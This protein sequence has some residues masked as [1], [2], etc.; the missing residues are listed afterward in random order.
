M[1][2]PRQAV[3]IGVLLA[4]AWGGC[5]Q[6]A[7]GP[8]P[9]TLHEAASVA[10]VVGGPVGIIVHT[11]PPSAASSDQFPPDSEFVLPDPTL[12]ERVR[13]AR[14][15]IAAPALRRELELQGYVLSAV[16]GGEGWARIARR[17]HC[18]SVTTTSWSP[19]PGLEY[20]GRVGLDIPEGAGGEIVLVVGDHG[21][22]RLAAESAAGDDLPLM[23]EPLQ[24][25]PGTDAPP[26]DFWLGRDDPR[27]APPEVVRVR[28]PASTEG[29]RLV[30]VRFGRRAPHVLARLTGYEGDARARV[31]AAPL[32]GEDIVTGDGRAADVLLDRPELYGAGW[33]G[34]GRVGA[35]VVRWAG[36]EAALLVSS[37]VDG[38][39]D[40]EVEAAPPADGAGAS[41]ELAVN[42]VALATEPLAPG[43]RVY[44]SRVPAG[45]WLA[46]TNE[47][48]L[49]V[50]GTT[51]AA[52]RDRT[53]RRD[54]GL[55]VRAVRIRVPDR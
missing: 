23:V 33:Y 42:G 37:R 39:V 4:V 19:L 38:P 2:S 30:G 45:I 21:P 1:T 52:E 53:A 22:V 43:F 25:A 49:R 36:G 29:R 6:G 46:G 44:T 34:E 55:G 20:S 10:W 8:D 51:R 15:M 50:S 14:T 31:C 35:D 13:D 26:V 16:P 7:D 54:L 9:Q 48:T 32:G 5:G 47:I 28:L 12:I 24:N 11:L 40:L 27:A 41:L 17:L 3:S 18:A